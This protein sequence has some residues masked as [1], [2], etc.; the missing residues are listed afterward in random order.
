LQQQSMRQSM[1]FIDGTCVSGRY[2]KLLI[3]KQLGIA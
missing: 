1:G 3:S 2:F